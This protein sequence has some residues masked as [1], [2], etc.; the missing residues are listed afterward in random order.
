MMYKYN[1]LADYRHYIDSTESPRIMHFWTGISTLVSV[2]R[3]N[4]HIPFG[5]I[6]LFP[7]FYI[8]LVGPAG[9]VQK[10]TTLSFSTN[11]LEEVNNVFLAPDATS[12]QKLLMCLEEAKLNVVDGIASEVHHCLTIAASEF[13]SIIA[14]PDYETMITWLTDLYDREKSF[15]YQTKN[16]GECNIHNP[17]IHLIACTTPTSLQQCLPTNAVGDGLTSRIIFV[18]GMK[19]DQLV[20]VPRAPA[21]E[22][23]TK[24][25]NGLNNIS[26]N[27][28][29][30]I[31]TDEAL[32]WWH[33]FYIGENE[34]WKPTDRRLLPYKAR[35]HAH[36][37]KLAMVLAVNYQQTELTLDC[38]QKANK[39]LSLTEINMANAFGGLGENDQLSNMLLICEVLRNRDVVPIENIVKETF[40]QISP[41]DC[42][43]LLRQMAESKFIRTRIINNSVCYELDKNSNDI[44]PI[45]KDTK[46]IG[47]AVWNIILN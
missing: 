28:Q 15:K 35:R 37:L 38:L 17:W 8:V 40:Q 6:K 4:Y 5:H 42:S 2:M 32:E 18:Y 3:R 1:W 45:E 36:I 22:L 14:G 44:M 47:E 21:N 7:Y 13:A 41:A 23:K 26:L 30:L 10:S 33:Q 16:A 25:I 34:D 12:P 20:S 19:K 24:L 39:I 29:A 9:V 43:N 31:F 11:L 46:V 27:E